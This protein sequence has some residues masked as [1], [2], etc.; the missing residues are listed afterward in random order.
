[1][2]GS[3]GSRACLRARRGWRRVY[4]GALNC[5]LV[6]EAPK[7]TAAGERSKAVPAAENGLVALG[8]FRSALADVA[9]PVHGEVRR[10]AGLLTAAGLLPRGAFNR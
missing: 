2:A 4:G 5:G 1:M 9:R 7:P 10:N 3:H 8:G 6:Q